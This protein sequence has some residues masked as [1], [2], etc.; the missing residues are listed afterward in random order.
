MKAASELFGQSRVT[1]AK[2]QKKSFDDEGK[3]IYI[4]KKWSTAIIVQVQQ[5]GPCNRNNVVTKEER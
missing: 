3:S 1:M 5:E 2:K 4:I